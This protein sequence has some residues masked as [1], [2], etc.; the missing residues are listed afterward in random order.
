MLTA[1]KDQVHCPSCNSS[2]SR[3]PQTPQAIPCPNPDCDDV[4]QES[5]LPVDGRFAVFAVLYVDG[6]PAQEYEILCRVRRAALAGM[7]TLTLKSRDGGRSSIVG[8]LSKSSDTSRQLPPG[9]EPLFQH[10]GKGGD[11]WQLNETFYDLLYPESDDGCPSPETER[12]VFR[13]YPQ[14]GEAVRRYRKIQD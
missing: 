12:K 5:R 13:Q 7:T 2:I 3:L 10:N 8:V 9:E 11:G 1:T 4:I 6:W 14:I